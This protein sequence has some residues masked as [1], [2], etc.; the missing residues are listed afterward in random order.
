VTVKNSP[1]KQTKQITRILH[2]LRKKWD[3]ILKNKGK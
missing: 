1:E 3:K 2:K